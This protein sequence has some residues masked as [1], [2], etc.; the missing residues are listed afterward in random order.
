MQQI[1]EINKRLENGS[2]FELD[3]HR[4]CVEATEREY[5]RQYKLF[6]IEFDSWERES[7]QRKEEFRFWAKF[8]KFP[9]GNT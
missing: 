4:K 9:R 5:R 1:D 6:N 8:E 2:T 7:S 3:F